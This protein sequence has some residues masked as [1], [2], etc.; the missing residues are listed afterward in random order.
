MAQLRSSPRHSSVTRARLP[1]SSASSGN[2]SVDVW[3]SSIRG[4]RARRED[5]FFYSLLQIY[6]RFSSPMLLI[7]VTALRDRM[8]FANSHFF[9]ALTRAPRDVRKSAESERESSIDV[10]NVA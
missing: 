4:S 10:Y 3:L 7:F 5:F 8:R 1:A 9:F 2:L 6:F